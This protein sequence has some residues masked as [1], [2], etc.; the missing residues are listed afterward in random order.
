MFQSDKIRLLLFNAQ[1]GR[2]NHPTDPYAA[3]FRDS[4]Y[5]KQ[6]IVRK[7]SPIKNSYETQ[8]LQFVIQQKKQVELLKLALEK[9]EKRCL[10]VTKKKNIEYLFKLIYH[11]YF[12]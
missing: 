12:S 10:L 9:T 5:V 6:G 8:F 11:Q 4:E 1:Y 2:L 7:L 3:L